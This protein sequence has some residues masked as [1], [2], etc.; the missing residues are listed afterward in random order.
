MCI[1]PQNVFYTHPKRGRNSKVREKNHQKSEILTHFPH[2]T[3]GKVCRWEKIGRGKWDYC[4]LGWG[5]VKGDGWEREFGDTSGT[6]KS[7]KI[8]PHPSIPPGNGIQGKAGKQLR[9]CSK[10]WEK[11]GMPLG[12]VMAAWIG[13]LGWELSWFAIKYYNFAI[14][15][16]FPSLIHLS[17][18]IQFLG[19]NSAADWV[20][21]VP[22]KPDFIGQFYTLNHTVFFR[23]S[24][25]IQNFRLFFPSNLQPH[26]L[27]TQI[28]VNLP[29]SHLCAKDFWLFEGKQNGIKLFFTG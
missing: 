28:K 22:P 27:K 25:K 4:H 26:Q 14:V 29:L 2:Q 16:P 18:I 23:Y 17:I 15:N 7:N 21:L 11:Q 3:A 10:L 8:H 5:E 20:F 24:S 9:D 19:S 6:N 13:N 12:V 1:N